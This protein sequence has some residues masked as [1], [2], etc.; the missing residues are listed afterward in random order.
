MNEP[1][2]W[3]IPEGS[4]DWQADWKSSRRFQLRYWASLSLRA[5][6]MAVEEMGELARK[7]RENNPK[8]NSHAEKMEP[9]QVR[10]EQL[11]REKKPT[12][13]SGSKDSTAGD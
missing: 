4:E 3:K 8:K 7:L 6:L 10:E 1:L 5:K 2:D 12:Y 13:E 9:V 11:V